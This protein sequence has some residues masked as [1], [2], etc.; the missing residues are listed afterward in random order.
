M[1]PR[2]VTLLL[3]FG[4]ASFGSATAA[5]VPVVLTPASAGEYPLG[6]VL[7]YCED[8]Q[9]T[10][11]LDNVLAGNFQ[12]IFRR[13]LQKNP[14]FT[15]TRSAFWLRFTVKNMHPTD[16][17]FILEYSFPTIDTVEFYRPNSARNGTND[18]SML[19]TGD[20]FPYSSREMP[21]RSFLCHVPLRAGEEQTIYVRIASSGPLIATLALWHPD[22]LLQKEDWERSLHGAF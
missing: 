1:I 5:P 18:Y 9:H 13:S 2:L 17:T 20:M 15:L 7:E 21:H 8:V 10:W 6:L 14:N 22:A 12:G 11:M 4:I 19:R 3:L 16:E